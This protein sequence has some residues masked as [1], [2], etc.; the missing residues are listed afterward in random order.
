MKELFRQLADEFRKAFEL[1]TYKELR[2]NF[3]HA[4]GCQ[5]GVNLALIKKASKNSKTRA[6]GFQLHC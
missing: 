2:A 3:P 6:M 4:P 1:P 5:G